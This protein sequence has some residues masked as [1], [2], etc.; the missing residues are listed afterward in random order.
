MVADIDKDF[1]GVRAFEAAKNDE[2]EACMAETKA[3]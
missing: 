2:F 3:Y 1:Q